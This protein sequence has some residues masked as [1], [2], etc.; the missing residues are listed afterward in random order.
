MPFTPI[1]MGPGIAIKAILQSS[2]SLMVFGWTQ[3]VMDIQPLIVIITGEGHLHGFTHTYIGAIIIAIIS[4]ISGKYFSEFGLKLLNIKG[5]D[6]IKITWLVSLTSAIIGSLSHVF[7]DSIMHSDVQPFYPFS[8][9]N[10][11]Q[12]LVS[13]GVLH[14]FCLYS[15]MIGGSVFFLINWLRRKKI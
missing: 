10:D 1:H 4:A 14:K 7:L 8:L 3:I 15:G 12:G 13:S 2:F 9:V 5:Q 6:E 11:F